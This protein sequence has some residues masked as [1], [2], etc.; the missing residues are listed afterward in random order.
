MILKLLFST[1]LVAVLLLATRVVIDIGETQAYVFCAIAAGLSGA[2]FLCDPEA[3]PASHL[4]SISVVTL[5]QSHFVIEDVHALWQL[6]WF[7]CGVVG[8][9]YV[10][11]YYVWYLAATHD[12]TAPADARIW[13]GP[14]CNFCLA[15]M[16]YI[17]LHGSGL[18]NLR[19]PILIL[20]FFA[21]QAALAYTEVRRNIRTA[22]F[23]TPH[24]ALK[25]LPLLYLPPH[26]WPLL[27]F[28]LFVN[29]LFIYGDFRSRKH[30]P[31]QKA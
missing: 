22:Q 25:C 3:A 24:P 29:I 11:D 23:S 6:E 17:P 21:I 1:L 8:S 19:Q 14:M 15:S 31:D 4:L 13:H 7:M 5:Y 28:F 18:F 9:V 16:A 26:L 12:D 20:V 10:A 27:L 2:W 30:T